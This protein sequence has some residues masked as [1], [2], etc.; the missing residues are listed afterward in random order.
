MLRTSHDLCGEGRKHVTIRR[1]RK[2]RAEPLPPWSDQ[3]ARATID[4]RGDLVSGHLHGKRVLVLGAGAVASRLGTDLWMHSPG[5]VLLADRSS[6]RAQLSVLPSPSARS[7]RTSPGPSG[8]RADSLGELVLRV[9]PDVVFDLATCPPAEE[10]TWMTVLTG[11]SGVLV[12]IL[13]VLGASCE[14]GVSVLV[15]AST[16]LAGPPASGAGQEARQAEQ[17]IAWTA[18]QTG[19][20]F[21][22]ARLGRIAVAPSSDHFCHGEQPT[23]S[24]CEC[25]PGPAMSVSEASQ[26]LILAA[27][28]GEPGESLVL[29]PPGVGSSSDEPALGRA[30]LR[31]AVLSAARP[32]PNRALGPAEVVCRRVHPWIAHTRVPPLSPSGLELV[33]GPV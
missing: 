29:D 6:G 1:A 17:L 11:A 25:Q 19:R 23:L 32:E 9:R 16:G 27:G 8:E 7:T 15:H 13:S 2:A 4:L 30:R 10:T 12:D 21:V 14:A 31:R 24:R 22:T 28:I 3:P 26:L 20:A 5:S 33:L 18:E